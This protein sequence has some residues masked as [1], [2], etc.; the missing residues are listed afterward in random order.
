[1]CRV[2]IIDSKHYSDA[3]ANVLKHESGSF[4]SAVMSTTEF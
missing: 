4:R 3:A 2:G 1:M